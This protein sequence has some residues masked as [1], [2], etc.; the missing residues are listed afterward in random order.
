MA[1]KKVKSLKKK[2]SM[3]MML[4]LTA[5]SLWGCGSINPDKYVTLGNYETLTVQV[6][7]YTYTEEDLQ[8][9]VEYELINYVEVL[10]LYEYQTISANTVAADSLVNIDYVITSDG[11]AVESSAVQ[12]EH[13]A[14]D[15]ENYINM[16][17]LIGKSVGETVVID[18][19]ATE[20]EALYFGIMDPEEHELLMLVTINAIETRQMPAFDDGLIARM[21]LEGGITTMDQFK[22]TFRVYLQDSCDSQNQTAKETAVWDAVYNICE[23]EE[24]PEELVNRFYEQRK[25]DFI[26]YASI[27]EDQGMDTAEAE[28][29]AAYLDDI[30]LELA[31]EEAKVELVYLAIAK[32]EGI[33]IS[34]K[35]LTDAAEEEY[36]SYGYE[37]AQA[38]IDDIGEE[39]YRS[40][41][42]RREVLERL[43]STVTIVD[44]T[45]SPVIVIPGTEQ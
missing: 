1:G 34:D 27:L 21:N 28:A 22:E 26:D 39:E 37:S 29:E 23:V 13:Y 12:G 19:S 43:S 35:Q 44:G 8:Q 42:L 30:I 25:Q 33:K 4:G 31:K 24:P 40:Q 17:E 16:D 10:D 7:R 15:A 20:E 36:Q 2:C 41:V 5:L 14:M 38:M 3:I 32:K 18:F 6:D 9:F 11:E 45:V